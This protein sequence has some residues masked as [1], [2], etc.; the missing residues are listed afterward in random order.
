MYNNKGPNFGNA[1]EIRIF[2]E[3]TTS[4]QATRLSAI[5]KEERADKL[6]II[7][8]CDISVN[9]GGAA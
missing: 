7:E 1:G 8:A 3:K 4:R 6:R 5:S 9:E 2:F